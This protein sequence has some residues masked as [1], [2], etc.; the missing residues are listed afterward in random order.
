MFGIRIRIQFDTKMLVS[1]YHDLVNTSIKY[2]R[3]GAKK[4]R[5]PLGQAHQ[6]VL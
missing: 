3:N 2:K 4:E 1:V 6:K 5:I